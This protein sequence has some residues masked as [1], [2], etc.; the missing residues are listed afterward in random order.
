MVKANK[1]INSYKEDGTYDIDELEKLKGYLKDTKYYFDFDDLRLLDEM[2]F[3]EYNDYLNFVVFQSDLDVSISGLCVNVDTNLAKR[4]LF[5][6]LI[7]NT[8]YVHIRDIS[9]S[10]Y[11]KLEEIGEAYGFESVCA[12]KSTF[13]LNLRRIDQEGE[14]IYSIKPKDMD[15]SSI[16]SVYCLEENGDIVKCKTYWSKDSVTFIGQGQGSY[17]LLRK[18]S[19]NT[20]TFDSIDESVNHENNDPDT[21]QFILLFVAY[22]IVVMFGVINILYH[23][24]I[25]DKLRNSALEYKKLLN[26]KRSS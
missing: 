1:N 14:M 6:G 8:Y 18:K 3:N 4:T 25:E 16:Y 26:L 13:S 21:Q 17:L 5:D 9:R 7:K 10:S 11:N 19:V 23:Y 20:Y 12:F 2:L 22:L 24:I 15:P